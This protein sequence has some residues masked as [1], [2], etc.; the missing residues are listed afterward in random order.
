MNYD[1]C[2]TFRYIQKYSRYFHHYQQ[3]LLSEKS[4][5]VIQITY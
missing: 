5:H 1:F 2:F 4:L 3:L